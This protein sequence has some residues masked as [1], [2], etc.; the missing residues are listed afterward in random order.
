MNGFS[1]STF[2]MVRIWG[3]EVLDARIGYQVLGGL[4]TTGEGQVERD[5]KQKCCGKFNTLSAKGVPQLRA[6]LSSIPHSNR[7]DERLSLSPHPSS[8]LL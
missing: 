1:I 3:V 5:G 2:L 6:Q 4:G 8:P 7:T